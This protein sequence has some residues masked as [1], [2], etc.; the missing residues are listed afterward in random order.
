MNRNAYF[1]DWRDKHPDYHKNKSK[2]SYWRLRL[3]AIKAY[4]GRCSQCGFDDVRALQFDHVGGGGEKHRKTMSI[5][6]LMF[7]LKKNNYPKIFQ[8]LC[9]NC[10]FIKRF[11]ECG[12]SIP[13][14][15]EGSTPV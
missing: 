5:R 3:E 4:G 12:Y 2:N 1:C 15:C 9:A 11:K 10:N 7:W 8:L 14:G 6:M 13:C